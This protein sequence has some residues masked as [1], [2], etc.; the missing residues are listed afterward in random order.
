M[1]TNTNT[2]KRQP[3]V[4]TQARCVKGCATFLLGGTKGQLIA[5][6][7]WRRG[8]PYCKGRLV[9]TGEVRD[10]PLTPGAG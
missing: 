10:E 6:G 9:K 1:A 5:E 2:P 7:T 4:S 3:R 8:C